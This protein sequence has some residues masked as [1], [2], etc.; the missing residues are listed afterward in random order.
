MEKKITKKMMF[1]EVIVM[2]EAQGR[3]DIVEFAEKEIVALEKKAAKA[4]E[5]AAKKRAEADELMGVVKSVLTYD[6]QTL[7]DIAAQIEGENISVAKITARMSKLVEAGEV[8]KEQ[9]PVEGADGK[10]TK[11]MAYKLAVCDG[12][13]S[14][15]A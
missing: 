15:E 8:V 3:A 11:K 9:V 12:E 4:K 13:E 6:F 5:A 1:E 14:V 7:G 2:A 10:K